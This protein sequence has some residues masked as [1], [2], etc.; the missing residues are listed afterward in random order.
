MK[1]IILTLILTPFSILFAQDFFIQ[2]KVDREIANQAAYVY[3]QTDSLYGTPVNLDGSFLITCNY[4]GKSALPQATFYQ[5]T[6]KYDHNRPIP[7]ELKGKTILL[8][9]AHIFIDVNSEKEISVTAGNENRIK[10]KFDLIE[11]S[12]LQTLEKLNTNMDSANLERYISEI[13]FI[14]SLTQPSTYAISKLISLMRPSAAAI[15]PHIRK[16]IENIETLATDDKQIRTVQNRYH[17][18]QKSISPDAQSYFPDIALNPSD[19]NPHFEDILL[20]SEYI[21]I[22]FWAT[23]CGPCIKQHPLVMQIAEKYK[24]IP[25]LKIVGIAVSSPQTAWKKYISS[26][27]FNYA[28]YWVDPESQQHKL[29]AYRLNTVPRYMLLRSHDKRI[30]EWSLDLQQIDQILEKYFE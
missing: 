8:D 20:N 5:S 30:V 12:Y 9:T 2:G 26:H 1:L 21:L 17:L 23:W 16:V 3:V 15:E 19:S 22:D 4:S 14:N 29:S 7:K 25:K 28:N 6:V 11:E 10:D 13:E 27:D 18:F 24:D